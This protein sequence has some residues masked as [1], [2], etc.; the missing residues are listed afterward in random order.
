MKGSILD[1]L[2]LAA[3]KP[4]LA[5]E[6]G[7]LAGRYDFEF[8]G[9]VSDEELESVAGGFGTGPANVEVKTFDPGAID[10]DGEPIVVEPATPNTAGS[11]GNIIKW[12]SVD[13]ETVRNKRQG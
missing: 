7:E 8:S 13:T 5:K 9:E 1:F 12:P 11:I 10:N 6:L 2:K 3:E 4:E